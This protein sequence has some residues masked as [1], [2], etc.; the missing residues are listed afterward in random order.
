[1]NIFVLDKDPKKCAEYHCDKHVVKMITEHN[2]MMCSNYNILINF[3]D[4]DE[5]QI[6]KHFHDFP[7]KEDGKIKPYGI[8]H[9][10]HPCTIWLRSSFQNTEWLLQ[11]N[12]FLCKEYTSRY[13]KI[14]KGQ[15]I[16]NWLE[17]KY[18]F[19][20]KVLP[21]NGLTDFP[22]CMPI[23]LKKETAV[24]AYQ[25]FYK[26]VKYTFAKWKNGKPDWFNA[27]D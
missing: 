4:L 14:H 15:Y 3:K 2:Q 21:N 13:Y 24:L 16:N 26:S 8:T 25:N 9:L 17:S 6:Q 27:K 22:Q 10:N 5:N 12:Y 1:M 11:M 7:R 20:K 18:D 19:F 23:D